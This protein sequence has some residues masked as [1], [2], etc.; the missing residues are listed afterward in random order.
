M[1]VRSVVPLAL[2]L[3]TWLSAPRSARAQD[4]SDR[5]Y[6]VAR[7][8]TVSSIAQHLGV[9]TRGLTERNHLEPPFALRIGRRLRLPDGVD[10]AVLRSLPLRDSGSPHQSSALTAPADRRRGM[11]QD[12]FVVSASGRAH[13][14][15]DWG[16]PRHPGIVRLVREFNDEGV[17]INLRRLTAHA[18]RRMEQFLRFPDGRH[19]PMNP[20]LLRQ[21][22][23]V[24]DHFGGRPLHVVSGFRPFRHGQWTAHSNHNIGAAMDFR[25]EGVSNRALREYCRT[26]PQTGCGFYPRSVFVHMDVRSESATW[27][28]WSRPGQRPMYGREDRAPSD[29]VHASA[30]AHAQ[31]SPE[32]PAGADESVDDVASDSTH[33][34]DAPPP[35]DN[36]SDEGGDDHDHA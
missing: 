13:G 11:R 19:H 18:R 27:V 15:R 29:T 35:P 28:D 4:A 31:P 21:V 6:V 3:A 9:A 5:V 34:R 36:G 26:L 25:V 22:A 8:D 20:R 30:T 17:T 1:L 32:E 16:R 7:G 14:G 2:A 24:S 33:V 23:I 12:A 10:V